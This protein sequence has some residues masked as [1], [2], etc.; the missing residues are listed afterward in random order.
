[1]PNDSIYIHPA[2]ARRRFEEFARREINEANLAEGALL[3][4]LEEYPRLDVDAYLRTLDDL[5]EKVAAR[6]NPEEPDVFRLGHIHYELF[7]M[8]GFNGNEKSYFYPN[9]SFLNEVIYRRTGIPITLSIIFIH[10]AQR[11]GLNASGVGLP[12]HYIVKVQFP[13]SE[14]YVDPFH[15]GRTLTV[16]EIDSMIS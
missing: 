7:D 6:M 12:G 14:V 4:A 15:A 16:G 5:V 3:V 8:A 11:V 2:E 1:M 13:L 9:N 10:V